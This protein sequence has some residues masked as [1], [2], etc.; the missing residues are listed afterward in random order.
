MAAL[1]VQVMNTVRRCR[2]SKCL[3][4]IWQYLAVTNNE[5]ITVVRVAY[6]VCGDS[7]TLRAEIERDADGELAIFP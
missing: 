4:M 7:H 3:L 2:N 1:H 6:S 5:R